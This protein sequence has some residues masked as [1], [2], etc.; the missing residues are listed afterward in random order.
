[1][2]YML[3]SQKDYPARSFLFPGRLQN[4]ENW[5]LAVGFRNGR[6]YSA[7]VKVD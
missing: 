5:T 1:M 4:L 2:Y 7:T 3:A 6:A